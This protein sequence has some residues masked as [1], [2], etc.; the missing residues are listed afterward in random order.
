MAGF[1]SGHSTNEKRLFIGKC[2]EQLSFQQP[3]A[4]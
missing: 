3:E 4:T 2:N 1:I